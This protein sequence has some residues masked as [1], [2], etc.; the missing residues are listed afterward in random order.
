MKVAPGLIL[1]MLG[2]LLLAAGLW[3]AWG[4]QV[5]AMAIGG[6]MVAIGIL[7]TWGPA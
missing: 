3:A 4:W 5:A 7:D 2:L 1:M 6:L